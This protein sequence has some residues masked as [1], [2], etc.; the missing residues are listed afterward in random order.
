[1]MTLDEQLAFWTALHKPATARRLANVD[2]IFATLA[3]PAGLGPDNS[4]LNAIADELVRSL[5]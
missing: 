2:S 3:N 5:Y 1:M 4:W